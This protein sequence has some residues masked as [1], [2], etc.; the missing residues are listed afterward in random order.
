MGACQNEQGDTKNKK[1]NVHKKNNEK[2]E[3]SKETTTVSRDHEKL[4]VFSSFVKYDEALNQLEG[5]Y[6]FSIDKSV[7]EE[8]GEKPFSIRAGISGNESIL[9]S[10]PV[11]LTDLHQNSE[12][13]ELK[14]LM[15]INEKGKIHKL[16]GLCPIILELADEHD[17]SIATV[18]IDKVNIP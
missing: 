17:Y 6:T 2:V 15:K 14:F 10:K 7:F 13:Q 11:L 3:E 1:G 12:K 8:M 5:S 16:Y 18:E 4:K 9:Y